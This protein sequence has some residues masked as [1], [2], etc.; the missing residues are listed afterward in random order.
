MKKNTL[1]PVLSALLLTCAVARAGDG[2]VLEQLQQETRV[3]ADAAERTLVRVVTQTAQVRAQR[4][5][6]AA[7]WPQRTLATGVRVTP[8]GELFVTPHVVTPVYG[9]LMGQPARVVVPHE[10]GTPGRELHAILADETEAKLT[11]VDSD[12]ELGVAVYDLPE[13]VAAKWQGLEPVRRWEDVAPGS[14]VLDAGSRLGLTLVRE[15]DP[16]LGLLK[17]D[18][19]GPQ[20]MAA[21]L[22]G[23]GRTLVGLARLRTGAAGV[24]YAPGAGRVLQ[25]APSANAAAAAERWA[26]RNSLLNL[27][28]H[29]GP[30]T[31]TVG[32]PG[33]HVAGPV[34]ARVLD[35]IAEHGRIRHS[36]LGVILGGTSGKGEEQGVEVSTV[37][38]GSPAAAAGLAAGDCV[39]SVDG[40]RVRDPKTLTRMLVLRRP[41]DQLAFEWRG[42]DVEARAKGTVTLGDRAEAQNGFV[43]EETLG[44][45]CTDLGP[46]LRRF[47]GLADEDSGAAIQEVRTDGAAYRAGLRRGDVIVWG[48]GGDIADVEELRAVL[49]AAKGS[50]VLRWRRPGVSD[51]LGG[52]VTFPGTKSSPR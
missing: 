13:D 30:A 52:T 35:D 24:V 26:A 9:V 49:A 40:V 22:I 10:A 5:V 42:A 2:S 4:G 50:V 45:K 17:A 21:A 8:N 47:M 51:V 44:L 11:L 28:P 34:V 14:F 32:P 39:L 19:D 15:T 36:Y 43:T 23:P 20:G 41:G 18:A 29:G 7:T 25:A 6:Y 38:E 33:S 27:R 1:V 46:S 3:L 12:A 16:A 37:L 31:A 48:G